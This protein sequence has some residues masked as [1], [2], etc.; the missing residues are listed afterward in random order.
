MRHLGKREKLMASGFGTKW[1]AGYRSSCAAMEM[2]M[3]LSTRH[4]V[5][6]TGPVT[7][8]TSMWCRFW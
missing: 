1:K 8:K 4:L 3:P 7:A 2:G 6:I 5:Y